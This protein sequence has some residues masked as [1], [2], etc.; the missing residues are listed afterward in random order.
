[1]GKDTK[2]FLNVLCL[3]SYLWVQRSCLCRK[4]SFSLLM[5]KKAVEC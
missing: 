1:M 4:A 5:V 3:Q 2:I